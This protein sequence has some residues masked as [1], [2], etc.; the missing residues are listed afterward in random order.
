MFIF[1]TPR[2]GPV[3]IVDAAR[4]N[5]FAYDILNCSRRRRMAAAAVAAS[6]VG[7]IDCWGLPAEAVGGR[8]DGLNFQLPLQTVPHFI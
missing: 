2:V 1:F 4:G 5:S 3:R 8:G 7:V 6:P